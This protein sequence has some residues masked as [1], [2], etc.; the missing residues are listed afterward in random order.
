VTAKA[1]ASQSTARRVA[2][3]LDLSQVV[4]RTKKM[5]APEMVMRWN[6]FTAE[7][8][9]LG[10]RMLIDLATELGKGPI[11]PNHLEAATLT[12]EGEPETDELGDLAVLPV[13][14]KSL[15]TLPVKWQG[16][17]AAQIDLA[18]LL[19]ARRFVVPHGQTAHIPMS[20]E[21]VEGMGKAIILH[22]TQAR[23]AAIEAMG[24]RGKGKQA[25]TE[26]T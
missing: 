12:A 16:E 25:A 6:G 23:F 8:S 9:V 22:F 7:C 26:E 20:V 10:S 2:K 14:E 5:N 3:P 19:A 24:K 11:K 1:S 4:V 15:S 13:R 21:E 17:S 18:K